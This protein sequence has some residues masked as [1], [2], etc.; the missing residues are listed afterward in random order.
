MQG[1]LS[2]S[3]LFK[4]EKAASGERSW[5]VGTTIDTVSQV[6]QIRRTE[7]KETLFENRLFPNMKGKETALQVLRLYTSGEKGKDIDDRE[8]RTLD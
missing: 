1:Q 3:S 5:V 2:E 4:G 6:T 8:K 7:R